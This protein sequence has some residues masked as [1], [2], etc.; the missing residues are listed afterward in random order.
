MTIQNDPFA[1]VRLGVKK[2]QEPIAQ[3]QQSLEGN[4][5]QQENQTQDPFESVRLK[6]MDSHPEIFETGRHA[7]RIG[8]RIAETIGGIPGDIGSLIQ[9]GVF[10][11]LEKLTGIPATENS[12]EKAKEY[13]APTSKELKK[14]SIES[15]GGYTKPTSKAEEIGDELAETIASLVGPM[16]FRKV[17][18]VGIGAQAAKEGI[19][20]LGG[21]ETSQ[22]AG[23]LGTMFLLS[24]L[25]PG[26]AMKYASSQYDTANKLAKGASITAK[27]FE[28]NLKNMQIGLEKGVE[29]S[30][31]N[32]ILKPIQDMLD[33]IKNGKIPVDELTAAKRDIS[34]LM[35]DPVL[36]KREKKLLKN[37]GKEIDDAIKPYEKI[38]PSFSKSYRPANEIYG[39]IMEGNKASNFIKK[40]LGAKSVLGAVMGEAF[41]GH[42]EFILPTFAGAAGAMAGAKTI[43]FMTRMARSPQLQKYYSKAM[44][45]S[46]AQDAG[47]LR[48]YEDKIEEELNKR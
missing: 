6:K 1:S 32:V 47:A 22:E 21:G 27:N 42:P 24:M 5:V 43:D 33:K 35:G 28:S 37:L 19:K 38:N 9:S 34:T 39:A 11:G 18:G 10:A 17:L 46:L 2:Q 45:A 26:G 48:L 29:T 14:M 23:K 40:H 12:R 30:S 8:S 25:N 13:R 31:K 36:L 7:T 44:S 20:L 15:S 3:E 4:P 16:K 41:L